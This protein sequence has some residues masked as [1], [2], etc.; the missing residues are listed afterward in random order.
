M[1]D[2]AKPYY[3][4]LINAGILHLTPESIAKK[5]NEIW[6]NVDAWWMQ[7]KVQ[8]ARKEFCDRYARVS[9]KPIHDLKK[10]LLSN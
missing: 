7:N 10:I 5:V 8:K 2:N 6:N 3:Q 1:R 9:N 4:L